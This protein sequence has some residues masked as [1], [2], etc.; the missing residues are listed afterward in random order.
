MIYIMERVFILPV[1]KHLP[2]FFQSFFLKTKIY[3]NPFSIIDIY[4]F[5]IFLWKKVN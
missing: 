2:R 4:H 5:G 3:R 1:I